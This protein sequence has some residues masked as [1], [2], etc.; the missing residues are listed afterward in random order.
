MNFHR[1][2]SSRLRGLELIEHFSFKRHTSIGCGGTASVCACP[3]NLGSA[4]AL[5]K[6]LEEESIPHLFLGAGANVLPADGEYKGVVVRFPYFSEL[7]FSDGTIVA[8]AGVTGG[9][10]CRFARTRGIGG[11]EPFT[12]IPMT[13]GGG[14]VMNAG[15]KE[16]HFSDV[17][18]K[19]AAFLDGKFEILSAD[20]C[21]FSEKRSLFQN[22]GAVLGAV[23]SAKE[24]PR[25][26]IEKK[27]KDFRMR[28][29]HLPKGRSMGC[30]FVNPAGDSAGK[31]ID[32]C[33]LKGYSS[34][35]CYVSP[36]HGNFI[37]N[38]GA[39]ARDIASLLEFVARTVKARKGVTLREE[40][41]RLAFDT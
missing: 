28:R 2:L 17:T 29:E 41:R 24:R 26:E 19:V 22:G 9:A 32:E 8:G 23:F 18:Q 36:L 11:F 31:L 39:T 33:G 7:S 4:V 30:C 38:E 14:I 13:V 15:V 10:L 5:L 37:I 21:G 6:F 40:I 25:E 35:K 12:G 3:L 34:G 20:E 27:T 16:G 1:L